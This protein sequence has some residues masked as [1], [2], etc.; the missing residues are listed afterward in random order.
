MWMS[1]VHVLL[2]TSVMNQPHCSRLDCVMQATFVC[3]PT[4]VPSPMNETDANVSSC[5]AVNFVGGVC[6]EG[7]HCPVG[8]S[9]PIPCSPGTYSPTEGQA[10]CLACPAGHYCLQDTINFQPFVCPTGHYCP[11]GTEHST[12]FPC[13]AGMFSDTLGIFNE[14][15]C[16]SCPVGQYCRSTGLSMPEGPCPGGWYC[17]GGATTPTPNSMAEGGGFCMSGSFCPEMSS[18]PTPCT[19]GS[20]CDQPYLD[21][22]SGL[23]AAGYYCRISSDTPTPLGNDSIGDICPVG[24]Y[25]PEGSSYPLACP[26]GTFS[27]SIGNTDLENCTACTEG[28]FCG[29]NSA[30]SPSGNCSAGYYCPAGQLLVQLLMDLNV[31]QVT[32]VQPGHL[33]Q[34]YVVEEPT[35]TKV[36]SLNVQSVLRATSVTAV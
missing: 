9:E 35:R 27:G 29:E 7:H 33:D 4:F 11:Q 36:G 12:Q 6:P 13:P 24:N 34:F 10:M 18:A 20:Y 17:S 2:D 23:C 1:A 22:P 32:F 16:N 28:M 5:L 30:A 25:C 19:N 31:L 15:E 14:S 26:S 21:A 3:W 8:T